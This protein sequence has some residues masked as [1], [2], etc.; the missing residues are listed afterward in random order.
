M[1]VSLLGHAGRGGR[2][3]IRLENPLLHA[4]RT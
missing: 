4:R 3:E 2:Y 1:F